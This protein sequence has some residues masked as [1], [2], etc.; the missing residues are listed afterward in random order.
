MTAPV[1][2]SRPQRAWRGIT[3]LCLV[4]AAYHLWALPD[5]WREWRSGV[6][7]VY[8]DQHWSLLMGHVAG[9]ALSFVIPLPGL[10]QFARTRV[11]RVLAWALWGALMAVIVASM[12]LWRW[13]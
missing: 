10:I 7:D 4:L 12:A 6:P 13:H 3:L 5:A 9:L 1:L 8:R 2:I 11:Q